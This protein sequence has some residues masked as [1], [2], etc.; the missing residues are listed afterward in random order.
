MTKKILITLAIFIFFLVNI[1]T[2]VRASEFKFN[3]VA[4]KEELTPGEEVTITMSIRD[5]NVESG[6]NT[7][8]AWLEYDKEIFENVKTENANDWEITY[9]TETGERYGKFLIIKMT[10]GQKEAEDVGKIKLNVKKDIPSQETEVKILQITSNDG[11][12]LIDEGDRIIKFKINNPNMD[13]NNDNNG[14]DGNNDN[15]ND[16]NDNNNKNDN[17]KDN[18]DNNNSNNNSNNGDKTNNN[19]N[20]NDQKNQ[21]PENNVATGDETII[22]SLTTLILAIIAL[23]I[24]RKKK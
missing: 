2:T 21:K 23:F 15:D 14:N 9:N 3:A 10:T 19:N 1:V 6:I 16:N 5:I 18:N 4:D 8:E 12:E 13:D 7:I 11:D 17:N 20:S 22:V 24:V